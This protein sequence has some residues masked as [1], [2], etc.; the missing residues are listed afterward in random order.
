MPIGKLAASQI[1]NDL[2][3]DTGGFT[4]PTNVYVALSSTDPGVDG[5][6]IT[7]PSGGGYARE[8]TAAADWDA[9]TNANPS[10]KQNGNAIDFGTA[11]ATWLSGN[12]LTHF[13]LWR[14]ASG[15]TEADFLYGGALTTAKPV[16]S[17]DPVQF[18]V[19]DLQV[20]MASS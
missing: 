17:G 12:N 11:S 2:F 20:N 18:P 6:S 19:G 5:Q 16:T 14:S 13:A 9:A 8:S 15:T 10:V 1:L 4:P 3:G 7:E